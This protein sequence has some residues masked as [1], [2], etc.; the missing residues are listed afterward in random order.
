MRDRGVESV[1]L[2][3]LQ[4]AEQAGKGQGDQDVGRDGAEHLVG[5][6]RSA[7]EHIAQERDGD[8]ADEDRRR[9]QRDRTQPAKAHAIGDQRI[10]GDESEDT[11][12]PEDGP[13]EAKRPD[14][15]HEDREQ[16]HAQ[17]RT[18][19]RRAGK[20]RIE[21]REK[22]QGGY[23][24]TAAVAAH[25]GDAAQHAISVHFSAMGPTPGSPQS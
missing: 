8:G 25:I 24:S 5:G 1:R 2:E 10:D 23:E 6:D 17:H 21:H 4:E 3:H 22:A 20:Q 13:F 11:Q 7:V 16:R 14:R 18:A 15:Q 9:P 19:D 12:P